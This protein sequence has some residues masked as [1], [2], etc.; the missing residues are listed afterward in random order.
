M[1]SLKP[2]SGNE[3][4]LEVQPINRDAL[5]Q[6]MF[7]FRIV[8]FKEGNKTWSSPND[9]LIVVDDVNDNY[10]EI[11]L[12]PIEVEILENTYLTLEFDKFEIND[13]DLVSGF[14]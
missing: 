3:Y 14:R 4:S 7:N 8:A 11:T 12:E 2:V 6:E 10:P 5:Q 13:I 1:I 9:A